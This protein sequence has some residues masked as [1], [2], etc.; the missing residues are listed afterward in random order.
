MVGKKQ[1][2]IP[3]EHR[4]MRRQRPVKQKRSLR[5]QDWQVLVG[6]LVL[7]GVVIFL[8][9]PLANYMEQRAEIQRLEAEIADQKIQKQ[10]LQEEIDRYDDDAFV[11][12]QA[13][14]RL[15]VIDPGEMAF[16]VVDPSLQTDQP[17]AD[18]DA[19]EEQ[20]SQKWYDIV[21]DSITVDESTEVPEEE[22]APAPTMELPLAPLVEN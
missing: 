9:S 2:E 18:E 1:R 15:G 11:R 20:A 5:L 4:T 14:A 21:W 3:V 10:Q 17:V 13:R 8:R 22:L 7:L 16:R 19:A 6:V 12:E